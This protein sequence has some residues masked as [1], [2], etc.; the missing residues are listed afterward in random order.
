[1]SLTNVYIPELE[2]RTSKM[3]MDLNDLRSGLTCMSV[4]SRVRDPV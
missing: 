2:N 1:M 3:H 4:S